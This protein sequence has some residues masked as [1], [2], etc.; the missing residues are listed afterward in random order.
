MRQQLKGNPRDLGLG[1]RAEWGG[2]DEIDSGTRECV[3][4]G[5]RS[6]NCRI[7]RGDS[8]SPRGI[9]I[10]SAATYK[11]PASDRF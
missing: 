8:S 9:Y 3:V 7:S 10:F 2:H 4:H 1:Q 11:S 5:G 6:L